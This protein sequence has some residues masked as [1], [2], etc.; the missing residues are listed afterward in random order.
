MIRLNAIRPPRDVMKESEAKIIIQA[1][2][3]KCLKCQKSFKHN[4]EIVFLKKSNVMHKICY[5]EIRRE[6]DKERDV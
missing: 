3:S 1:N 5:E 2:Y 4:D 6:V